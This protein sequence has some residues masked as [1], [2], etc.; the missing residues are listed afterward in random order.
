MQPSIELIAGA[1]G[2]VVLVVGFLFWRRNAR[3][4]SSA[5]T[6]SFRGPANMHFICAACS[7]QFG[8]TRR[9]VAAWEKGSRRAFCDACHKK[10]RNAQPPQ[11]AQPRVVIAAS[12]RATGTRPA[13]VRVANARHS[14]AAKAPG[15]CFGVALLLILLPA[16]IFVVVANA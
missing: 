14:P 8:H 7:G 11:P 15:G 6:T 1:V 12:D 10:W 9:T 13:P 5:K 16:A 3:H 2:I 4:S